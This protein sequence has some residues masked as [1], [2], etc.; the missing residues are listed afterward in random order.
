MGRS[1]APRRVYRLTCVL[2]S[3]Q[4]PTQVDTE[5]IY[6]LAKTNK[7]A[8]LEEFVAAPN[9]ANIQSIGERLFDEG[10]YEAAKLL[11]SN[12]NNNA[13]LALCFINLNQYR[14]AVDAAQKANSIATWKEVNV[15]CVKVRP[16][17]S[18]LLCFCFASAV[19]R[20]VDR[21]RTRTQTPNTNH[22]NQPSNQVGEFRLAAICGLHI[23][24]H[25]DHLEELIAHY[26]RTGHPTE[27]MQLLEQGLGL[28]GAHSGVFTELGILY[29]KYMPE[30][31]MEHL[32]IFHNRM[33]V[34]KMLRACEKALLWD[35]TVYLY[36][37]DGQPDNAVKTMVEHPI[38]FQHEL[39]LD[40]IQKARNQVRV[41]PL[42]S[43]LS[44][45]LADSHPS[46]SHKHHNRRCT[47]VLSPSTSS[48]TPC[49]WSGS[50]P[51]SR[52]ISTTPASCTSSAAP[53]PS[54]SSS[55]TSSAFV[56][57]YD[58]C[59]NWIEL[60]TEPCSF[61]HNTTATGA[62]RRRTSRW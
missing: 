22:Q 9:V 31:L 20:S 34:P 50:S 8:E 51:C 12:I 53:S 19:G 14:E 21:S 47:T 29:S 6:S 27:L 45:N 39:F 24:V 30:K 5:Y 58:R 59:L 41:R 43:P 60:W 48:S 2:P 28:E 32:K 56:G 10:N 38:A 23:I 3:P 54:R 33:N 35:E 11:F 37:E 16:S 46:I 36:K 26:E 55:P 44:I 7:L 52:P 17:V 62:C 61:H 1:L 13:K 18:V 4:L 15:A 49:S 25:P 42:L 40:C 57:W